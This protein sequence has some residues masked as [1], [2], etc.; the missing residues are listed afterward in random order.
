MI[1]YISINDVLSIITATIYFLVGEINIL[2]LVL[3]WYHLIRGVL[4]F[5]VD[6]VLWDGY[7]NIGSI[8]DIAVGLVVFF[9]DKNIE[10]ILTFL[11]LALL[12]KSIYNILSPVDKI[13]GEE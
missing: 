9:R 12:I 8:I 7:I 4:V 13:F 6:Y 3:L 5:I 10:T 1:D 2:L 11:F